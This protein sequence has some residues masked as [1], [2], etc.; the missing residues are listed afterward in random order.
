MKVLNRAGTTSAR[1]RS[2]FF[3]S[4][5]SAY[6]FVKKSRRCGNCSMLRGCEELCCTYLGLKDGWDSQQSLLSS[7]S[8]QTMMARSLPEKMGLVQ[9]GAGQELSRPVAMLTII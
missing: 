1:A 7:S 3:L 8:T 9:A 4:R 6:R 2:T 5:M